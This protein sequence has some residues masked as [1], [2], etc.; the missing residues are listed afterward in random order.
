MA[1]IRRISIVSLGLAVVGA[2][3]GGMCAAIVAAVLIVETF[4]AGTLA[5]WDTA[6]LLASLG[7]VGAGLGRA[8]VPALAW[9]LL[10]RVPVGRAVGGVA[11]GALLGAG[12]G[13]W[14]APF[15]PYARHPAGFLIGAAVGFLAAGLLLRLSAE[16]GVGAPT[17]DAAA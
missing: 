1:L 7:A 3:A 4:G 17:G 2:V 10:R 15:N 5:H 8:A 6:G 16:R 11:L 14:L 13:E 12:V 9:L